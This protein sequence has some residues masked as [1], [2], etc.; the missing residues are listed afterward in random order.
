MDSLTRVSREQLYKLD[1]GEDD[2][3]DQDPGGQPR[4]GDAGTGWPIGARTATIVLIVVGHGRTIMASTCANDRQ[5]RGVATG[6]AAPEG[7][8]SPEGRATLMVDG[9]DRPG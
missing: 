5:R 4:S 7:T 9:A 1:Q 6:T 3:A 2:E 8:L